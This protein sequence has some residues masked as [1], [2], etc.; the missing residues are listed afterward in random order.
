MIQSLTFSVDPFEY[1]IAPVPEKSTAIVATVAPDAFVTLPVK[2]GPWL[3][4]KVAVSPSALSTS[5]RSTLDITD[6]NPKAIVAVPESVTT[7]VPPPIVQAGAVPGD[8]ISEPS[9]PV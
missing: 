9:A 6:A 5:V 1:V 2:P 3:E 4:V 8:N 7:F